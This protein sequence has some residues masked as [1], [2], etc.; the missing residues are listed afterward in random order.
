MIGWGK[1]GRALRARRS[2]GSE[3]R[4]YLDAARSARSADPTRYN[5][6]S[7]KPAAEGRTADTR[8]ADAPVAVTCH[9]KE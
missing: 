9:P 6:G 4:P 2:D 1:V 8:E 5:R 7:P 3:N